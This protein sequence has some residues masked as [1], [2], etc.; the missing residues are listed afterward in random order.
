V[1]WARTRSPVQ[2]MDGPRRPTPGCAQRAAGLST[3]LVR[4]GA[5]TARKTRQEQRRRNGERDAAQCRP[6]PAL[7]NRKDPPLP[8][9][10]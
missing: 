7:Q 2:M 8:Q 9:L 10:V 3:H 4:T 6:P 1:A 5:Q